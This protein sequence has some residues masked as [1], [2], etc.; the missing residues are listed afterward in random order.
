MMMK[1]NALWLVVMDLELNFVIFFLQEFVV[2]GC[3][4]NKKKDF[5]SNYGQNNMR[6]INE[7]EIKLSKDKG[8]T[9]VTMDT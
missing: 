2:Y 7:P 1:K 4:P 6:N 3:D 5:S 8:Y 9:Q